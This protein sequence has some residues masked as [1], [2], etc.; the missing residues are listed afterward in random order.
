M[1]DLAAHYRHDTAPRSVA[2]GGGL[3][4]LIL[5]LALVFVPHKIPAEWDDL[6]MPQE[7]V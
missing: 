6:V 2:A 4:F 1:A 5:V 7:Y 3:I